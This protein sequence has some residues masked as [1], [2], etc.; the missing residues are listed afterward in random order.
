MRVP[1]SSLCLSVASGL[2]ALVVTACAPSSAPVHPRLLVAPCP[3]DHVIYAATDTASGL[4]RPRPTGISFVRPTADEPKPD[5]LLVRV[6]VT[7]QGAVLPES[8]R[9]T[10][11]SGDPVYEPRLLDAVSQWEFR[12]ATR[13]SCAVR[14][15]FDLRIYRDSQ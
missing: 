3:S 12:P 1:R 9:V 5:T 15:W 2:A 6:V 10:H 11:P 7:S 4:Q 13:G 14:S 8:T